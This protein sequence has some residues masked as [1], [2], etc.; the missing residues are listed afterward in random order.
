MA[1]TFDEQLTLADVYAAALF[2]L[3]RE[4]DTIAATRSELEE[5]VKLTDVEPQFAEFMR[6]GAVDD[7]HR[8]ESLERM[9]RGKLSDHVLN[10]LQVMNDHGR[11]ALLAPL[12]RAFVLREGHAAGRIEVTATT[13]VELDTQQREEV[14]KLAAEL[15]GK[16]PL[17]D[18]Q[19]DPGVLGGLVLQ[20]GDYR[21]DDSVRR[22]LQ[23]AGGR[24][25]ERGDRGVRAA[26]VEQ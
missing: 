25:A 7:D 8:R 10:T 14:R 6:S 24:L 9:F 19:V 22:H 2:A 4:S 23:I 20:I 13:A 3:A 26:V 12:L 5:L 1:E 21:F 17:V 16:E 18:Y 15:S 11:A